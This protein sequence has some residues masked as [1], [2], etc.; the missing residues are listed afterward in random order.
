MPMVKEVMI[1]NER[2]ES[3]GLEK[4]A[5][6]RHEARIM[7]NNIARRFRG[8]SLDELLLISSIID[9]YNHGE[10]IELPPN[11]RVASCIIRIL[12]MKSDP[13]MSMYVNQIIHRLNMQIME[14]NRTSLNHKDAQKVYYRLFDDE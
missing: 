7:A 13:K 1:E 12:R 6:T 9:K 4:D 14:T 11:R 2:E 8:M 5:I 10:K 3:N